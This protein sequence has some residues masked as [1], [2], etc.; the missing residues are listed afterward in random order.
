MRTFTLGSRSLLLGT[1]L[2]AS[3]LAIAP[4]FVHAQA[5]NNPGDVLTTPGGIPLIGTNSSADINSAIAA[6]QAD[7]KNPT[8]GGIPLVGTNSK[9]EVDSA[10]TAQQA[11]VEQTAQ[12]IASTPGKLVDCVANVG[13]CIINS[14][15]FFILGFA[16]YLLGIVGVLLNWV[17]VK[18]VFQF[19]QLI[20]N[21]AGLLTAWKILRDIGNLLLL[22]G[23]VLMGI[24]TIL[25]TSKLPDKKAIPML[26]VFAVLLNFSIFAAEAVIDT[27]NVLTSVLYSQ[28]NTNPCATEVCDINNG[29]A[30]HIMQSTGLS[31]IYGLGNPSDVKTEATVTNKL[32]IVLGLTLFSIIGAVVLL[33]TAIMLAWRAVVLT[34]LIILS[35]IGFAGMALPPLKKMASK[36]WNMLIHQAFFAPILFLLI[37]VDLKVTEGFSS[38]TNNQNLANALTNSSSNMGIIM[39]FLLIIAGLLAAL[40]AAKNFGAMG[41]SFAVNTATKAVF[42]SYNSGLGLGGRAIRGVGQR[43]PG[44]KDTAFGRGIASTGR[45]IEHG[46]LDPRGYAGIG[47]GIQIGL[48]AAGAGDAAKPADSLKGVGDSLNKLGERSKEDRKKDEAERAEQKAI[49]NKRE[50]EAHVRAGSLQPSS[51][52]FLAGLSGKNLEDIPA[53]RRGDPTIIRALSPDQFGALMNSDNLSSTEKGRISTARFADLKSQVTAAAAGD[54]AARAA[55]RQ[56]TNK[57]LQQLAKSDAEAFYD[58]ISA[59]DNSG[60]SLLSDDQQENLGKSDSLTR[61]QRENVKGFSV[62]GRIEAA[63]APGGAGGVVAQRLAQ[64]LNP[65]QKFKL[66]A[67]ALTNPGVIATFSTADLGKI[68]ED[69]KLND[70]QKHRIAVEIANPAH[71]NATSIGPYLANNVVAGAYWV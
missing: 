18:T 4:L 41:A 70:V 47:R 3:F 39:V 51:E 21:S 24:G 2:C 69:G 33:A 62:V 16:N 40:I 48:K 34:G 10:I 14:V 49:A 56:W 22:F 68:M 36:W 61:S 7:L 55:V 53:V 63:V 23:F 43:V 20:G 6:T 15:A 54:P 52:R 28:A 58:V 46:G 42:G 19:S 12:N 25:D 57:D 35:P 60:A 5:A 9:A 64:T 31:S 11:S 44:L 45:F 29:L 26:I 67:A 13:D 32:L 38:A 30:G 1:L 66:N 59:E 65:K 8:I 37:F 50:L 27:S 17:V 71:P